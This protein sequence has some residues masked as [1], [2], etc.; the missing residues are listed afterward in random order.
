[1]RRLKLHRLSA[2]TILEVVIAIALASL[3]IIV[4]LSTLVNSQ[5][6]IEKDMEKLEFIGKSTILLEYVKRDVRNARRAAD[7]V[8]TA[9][10]NLT[11]HTEDSEGKKKLIEYKYKREKQFVGRRVDEGKVKWFGRLGRRGGIITDFNVSP[12]SDDDYHGFYQVRV[13]FMSRGD[14]IRQKKRG[15]QRPKARKTH[16]FQALVNRRTPDSVDDKWNSA[17]RTR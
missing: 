12:V 2:F 15:V 6:Q 1:M 17:F 11:I 10:D 8:M 16:T 9:G 4:I 3:I 14:Y 5:V 13:T 7:S